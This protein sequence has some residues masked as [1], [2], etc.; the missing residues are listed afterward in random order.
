MAFN[1]PATVVIPPVVTTGQ[2]ITATQMNQIRQAEADLWTN[3]QAISSGALIAPVTVNSNTGTALVTVTNAGSVG[4]GTTTPGYFPSG[5]GRVY[6]TLKS[7]SSCGVFEIATSG[8]DGSGAPTAIMQFID[9]NIAGADKRAVSIHVTQDGTTANNR[10][11]AL[12]FFTR[13]DNGTTIAEAM[14]VTQNGNVGIGTTAPGAPL[15]V[16]SSA[17]NVL[18]TITNNGASGVGQLAIQ[19]YSSSLSGSALALVAFRGSIASP[20]NLALGDRIGAVYYAGSLGLFG[21]SASVEA[22]ADDT[23]TISAG[24][25]PANLR[26][27]TAPDGTI[28]R[29]ERMR[30]SSTGSVGIGTQAPGY[31]ATAGR[32]Y[33]TVKGPT[34]CGVLE[35]AS[36]AADVDGAALGIIQTTDINS[37]VAE[38]RSSAIVLVADGATANNRGGSIRLSTKPDGGTALVEALRITNAGRVGIGLTGPGAVLHVSA[39]SAKTAQFD[40][41]GAGSFDTSVSVANTNAAAAIAGGMLRIVSA[42]SNLGNLLICLTN[43]GGGVLFGVHA[44]GLIQANSMPSTNPGAGTKCL[45]YDP[46]DGNRVKFAA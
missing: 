42:N 38:K 10:G 37:N 12:V 34:N 28:A 3:Q 9:L 40:N 39:P 6:L 45:W 27:Y 15:S 32:T 33:L 46:A 44:S 24:S 14:R 4:I 16:Q 36:G 35:L 5:T 31:V 43:P 7:P 41:A 22:Y 11:G 23:G 18:G 17:T 21:A 19:N 25:L 20:A 1:L 8:A 29:V 13:P 2:V 30:I 26:F